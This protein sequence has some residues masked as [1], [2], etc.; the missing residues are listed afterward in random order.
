MRKNE[1]HIKKGAKTR[2]DFEFNQ[3]K[4][5]EAFIE[6]LKEKKGRRPTRVELS[7]RTG[8]HFNTI[9]KHLRGIDFSGLLADDQ[10]IFRVLTDDII[11]AIYRAGM[12]GNPSAQKLWM[13]YVE[14][15]TEKQE[16]KHSGAITV[17]NTPP[18]IV[19]ITRSK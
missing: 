9:Q 4:I 3:A 11:L 12:K 8:I 13:Q 18:V 2:Q 10:K 7:E 6:L 16:T 5:R 17:E 14:G 15:W 19:K 1:S